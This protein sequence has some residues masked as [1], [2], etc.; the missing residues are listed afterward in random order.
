MEEELARLRGLRDA[1]FVQEAE[2]EWRAACVRGERGPKFDACPADPEDPAP[3][4]G[5]R[6]AFSYWGDAPCPALPPPRATRAEGR[7]RPQAL[8]PAERFVASSA[9]EFTLSGPSAK[10]FVESQKRKIVPTELPAL[11]VDSTPAPSVSPPPPSRRSASPPPSAG[12]ATPQLPAFPWSPS[13]SPQPSP[14]SPSVA[15]ART[16]PPP[17]VSPAPEVEEPVGVAVP[18]APLQTAN[19]AA[20]TTFV[21]AVE[22]ALAL[23]QRS[24]S[25]PREDEEPEGQLDWATLP[26][27]EK[28]ELTRALGLATLEGTAWQLLL[29]G[30]A[31]AELGLRV[32]FAGPGSWFD[33]REAGDPLRSPCYLGHTHMGTALVVDGHAAAQPA[34]HACPGR[35]TLQEGYEVALRSEG[36]ERRKLA[37]QFR[38]PPADTQFVD[39]KVVRAWVPD[40][41]AFTVAG[42]LAEQR[43]DGTAGVRL[44]VQRGLLEGEYYWLDGSVDLNAGEMRG[45]WRTYDSPMGA[46]TSWPLLY[47]LVLRALPAEQRMSA[48]QGSWRALAVTDDSA[49]A[50]RY[51]SAPRPCAREQRVSRRDWDERSSLLRG[52]VGTAPLVRS[53]EPSEASAL[54]PSFPTRPPR[55]RWA[56]QSPRAAVAAPQRPCAVPRAPVPAAATASGPVRSF[57]AAVVLAPPEAL[58]GP[59]QEV[60]Q[61][62]DRAFARWMP[63][64]NVVWPFVDR[65]RWEHT[66]AVQ[67]LRDV[68]ARVAPFRVA[69][70]EV[71]S[72]AHTAD[73][74]LWLR[75][76]CEPEGR[77]HE[78]QRLLAD[79]FPELA[80]GEP[81]APREPY[82][83][84]LT[85]G[86]WPKRGAAEAVRAMNAKWR[87]VEWQAEAIQ[88]IC[89]DSDH[90]PFHVEHS[91]ALGE[92]G[93]GSP[94]AS[95]PPP[96]EAAGDVSNDGD[97]REPPRLENIGYWAHREVPETTVRVMNLRKPVPPDVNAG[98]AVFVD[99][100]SRAPR[101][102]GWQ[103]GL[104][105]FFAGPVEL[106]GGRVAELVENAWQ[107]AKVYPAMADGSGE[108]TEQY[109]KW[110]SAGWASREAQR[111][112]GGRGAKP[113]YTLWDGQHLPYVE[114]RAR[115]YCPLYAAAVAKTE[116]FAQLK[117]VYKRC[118]DEGKMLVL[119]DYDGWDHVGQGY[120]LAEVL[121]TQTLVLGHSFVLAGLLEGNLFWLDQ[122]QQSSP[123]PEDV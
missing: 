86:Q 114:A 111:Y 94:A 95:P 7:G 15:S 85:L 65:G 78:L 75:P 23:Q 20:N 24:S 89:R 121:R 53:R 48:Q 50:A 59:I 51:A 6:Y 29:E 14:R 27:P 70:R 58:W 37:E 61:A 42:V 32:E 103:R 12:R 99:V 44:S 39:G 3:P 118:V 98:N 66:D 57:R 18:S 72:F 62:H 101:S 54:F 40:A 8:L 68:A 56:A 5:P 63:H 33:L 82:I 88:L 11:V 47:E 45:T 120:S 100:T 108:P 80:P 122:Q 123:T 17:R 69:L 25:G 105:P 71:C 9:A 81:N 30:P 112:P 104:S 92:C 116:S 13:E 119:M 79:E 93:T 87:S 4:L 74:V 67:R 10:A 1:G 38:V 64:V 28:T 49:F 109:W 22:Q 115:V 21:V 36:P 117:A 60:R 113:L 83:P 43:A 84:H 102:P 35:V 91:I 16:P 76:E 31:P 106:Y 96:A 110:A 107:F 26:A 90:E 34:L 97:A 19:A 46:G 2:Y 55:S 41:R 52:S 77:L 73:S